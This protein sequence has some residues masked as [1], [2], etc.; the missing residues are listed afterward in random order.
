M[1]CDGWGGWEGVPT[2]WGMYEA[3]QNA[4]CSVT[5]SLGMARDSLVLYSRRLRDS[6]WFL[7][8]YRITPHTTTGLHTTTL[9]AEMIMASLRKLRSTFD[10]LLPDIKAKVQQ[11][12]RE[13]HDKNPKLWVFTT[14]DD[15]LMCNYIYGPR[16]I[17]TVIVNSSGPVFYTIAV[18]SGKIL[19][20]HVEQIPNSTYGKLSGL[21]PVNN[22]LWQ[23]FPATWDSLFYWNGDSTGS[24][25]SKPGH[26]KSG[27]WGKA[28]LAWQVWDTSCTTAV[29]FFTGETPPIRIQDYVQ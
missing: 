19:K 24:S 13:C 16:W 2:L 20:R 28:T 4:F 22:A 14:G 1:A 12:Q 7:F 17:P 23:N 10:L 18:G 11:K 6:S 26:N 25:H 3:Q 15:I 27:S 21:H 5:A 9:P 8:N 29:S